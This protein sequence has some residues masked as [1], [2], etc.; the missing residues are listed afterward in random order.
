MT[1]PSTAE[2]VRRIEE[3]VRSVERLASTLET[4]YVRKDTHEASQRLMEARMESQRH[5]AE[6][7]TQAVADDAA[8]LKRDRER[9][10][11]WR[12]QLT[13]GLLTTALASLS[14]VAIA[15]FNLVAGG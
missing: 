10:A 5:A 11:D 8:D 12:R 1:D 3:L 9:D 7:A 15:I 13:A 2:I 6:R 4:N 14:G